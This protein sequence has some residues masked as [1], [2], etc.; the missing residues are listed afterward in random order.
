MQEYLNQ[1]F[2][3]NEE[4]KMNRDMFSLP[5]SPEIAE[6]KT[7]SCKDGRTLY[8]ESIA[9][10]FPN[11]GRIE[12]RYESKDACRTF[13]I[14]PDRSVI[15]VNVYDVNSNILNKISDAWDEGY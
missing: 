6:V 12:I 1:V 9:V 2:A 10:V 11:Q 13:Q 4:C 14:R 8:G 3:R 7:E 5:S 15:E